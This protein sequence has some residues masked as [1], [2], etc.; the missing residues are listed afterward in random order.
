MATNIYEAQGSLITL[1][2]S[3]GTVAI[4]LQNLGFGYGIS[5]ALI[6]LGALSTPRP[7]IYTVE[8][9]C[10]WVA[11]PALGEVARLYIYNS[12]GSVCDIDAADNAV[13]P[14]TKFDNFGMPITQ[15]IVTVASDQ[16]FYAKPGIA[17][18]PQRYATVA[19]WNASAA[20]NLV[21]TANV[22]KIT[23]KPI[24]DQAQ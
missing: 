3:G 10:K 15:V 6:D 11:T 9:E 2:D 16:V 21:N 17:Y 14:E 5:G 18:L 1:Q 24:F 20:K 12:D 7:T 19:V 4:A 22:C 13:T 8:F 23:L